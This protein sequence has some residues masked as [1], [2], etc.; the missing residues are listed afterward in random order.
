MGHVCPK[1]ASHKAV[2]H[3]IVLRREGEGRCVHGAVSAT[4][5]GLWRDSVAAEQTVSEV[6]RPN[7]DS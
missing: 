6:I 1:V 7:G 3:S 2:P 4:L 5:L